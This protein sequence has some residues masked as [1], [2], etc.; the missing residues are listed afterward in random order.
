MRLNDRSRICATVLIRSVL[1]SPGTPVMRQCPPVNKAM[2]T[3]SITGSCPT[4]T[5]RISARMRSRPRETRSATAAMSLE[6]DAA[7]V[8][9]GC[10][11]MVVGG[12]ING[13]VGQRVD[14]FVYLHPVRLRGEPDVAGV[15]GRV[16]PLPAVAHVGVPVDEHH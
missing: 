15:V 7:P 11:R 3:W 1:A 2:R 14:D 8:E 5:F 6:P 12:F 10:V 9:S 4:M 13:S 16:R